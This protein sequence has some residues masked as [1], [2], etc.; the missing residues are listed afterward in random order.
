MI[1]KQFSKLALDMALFI[2]GNN[3]QKQSNTKYWAGVFDEIISETKA[4]KAI[5]EKCEKHNCSWEFDYTFHQEKLCNG[6]ALQTMLD[7]LVSMQNERQ[8]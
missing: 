3:A 8:P 4:P 1:T 5:C 2:A 7:L 6:C